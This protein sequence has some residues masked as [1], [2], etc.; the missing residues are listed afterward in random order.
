MVLKVIFFALTVLTF[1]YK[2]AFS[3]VPVS[4]QKH[5]VVF[6]FDVSDSIKKEDRSV[7]FQNF[8]M[9][10]KE[11]GEG[12]DFVVLKIGENSQLLKPISSGLIPI[13]E[14]GVT[15][16]FYENEKKRVSMQ[17]LKQVGNL[18]NKSQ[19]KKTSIISSIIAVNDYFTDKNSE[20]KCIILFSDMVE[21]S[22]LLNMKRSSDYPI[23]K[24]IKLN[25]N[26][27]DG[28][29]VYVLGV[30][31]GEKSFQNVKQFWTSFFA[32]YGAKVVYYQNSL[33]NF[34]FK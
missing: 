17:A 13:M 31:S 34:S 9:V 22:A 4:P 28:A 8:Q 11:L 10:L 15:T 24:Y 2:P 7:Y 29:R 16:G 27:V 32:Q 25:P 23:K 1:F 14:K 26:S 33:T 20:Y 21:E 5:S 30:N 3:Q 6:L 12:D 19:D 18:L